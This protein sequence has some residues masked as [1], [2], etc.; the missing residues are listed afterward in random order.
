LCGDIPQTQKWFLGLRINVL[1]K[2]GGD[3]SQGMCPHH[4]ILAM[5]AKEISMQIAKKV[6]HSQRRAVN[7]PISR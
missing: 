2:K 1:E 3:L 5:T 7:M 4:Y 6:M